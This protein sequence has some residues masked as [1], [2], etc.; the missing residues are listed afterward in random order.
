MTGFPRV[1][2]LGCLLG[3]VAAPQISQPQ[4]ANRFAS[5]FGEVR[6]AITHDPVPNIEVRI[7]LSGDPDWKTST[8]DGAGRYSFTRL[9]P[10]RYF[11]ALHAPGYHAELDDVFLRAGIQSKVGL[12]K[13]SVLEGRVTDDLGQPVAGIEVCAL[14]RGRKRERVELVPTE[15][16][17]TNG[18][19]VF[20]LSRSPARAWFS[21]GPGE[22]LLAVIPTGCFLAETG[23]PTRALPLAGIVPTYFPDVTS[24]REATVVTVAGDEQQSRLDIK[25]RRGPSTRLEGRIAPL[26]QHLL[27]PVA[28]VI[29]EPPENDVPIT[30][31]LN[32]GPDGRFA[33][34]G[35]MPGE[36]R[37]IVPPTSR[38]NDRSVWASQPVTVS[39]APTQT[40]SVTT[41]PTAI[42]SGRI[43]FDG[44]PLLLP[45][46]RVFLTVNLEPVRGSSRVDPA[47]L[48]SLFGIVG[49]DGR[50]SIPGVMP[51]TYIFSVSGA[52]AQ[53]WVLDAATIPSAPGAAAAD[54][55]VFNLPFTIPEEVDI[56]GATL[57]MTRAASTL[58]VML[59]DRDDQPVPN[60][61]VV[62]FAADPKYWYA[63]SRR[64]LRQRA[65]TTGNVTFNN[66]PQ[67]DYV[68]VAVGLVPP[69]WYTA[70]RLE[71]LVPAGTRVRL[72]KSDTRAI[73]I[74]VDPGIVK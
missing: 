54:R 73:A 47:F 37:L 44:A 46:V 5:L 56:L 39:G 41:K 42:V 15:Y 53:G 8:T 25:L 21:L 10:G 19:G 50:F 66:L 29:L 60:M 72:D 63:A 11:V 22:F 4:P 14:R 6:S 70:P 69:D 51:G 3:I 58:Q 12:V 49:S 61:D 65:S 55:D 9:L 40:V 23:R 71:A 68:A 30:R 26:P 38:L 17:I 7:R 33:F 32:V 1:I 74:R 67:G 62:L 16:A 28:R 27:P 52:D 64:L 13:R 43:S 18:D 24:F 48:P 45:G 59:R 34:E 20:R 31:V 2:G 57:A 36:Y 35:V